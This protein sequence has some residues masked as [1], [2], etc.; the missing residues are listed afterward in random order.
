MWPST[1]RRGG[2]LRTWSFLTEGTIWTTHLRCWHIG[3]A[4]ASGISGAPA[5]L[6]RR[7]RAVA[8]LWALRTS[9][10]STARGRKPGSVEYLTVSEQGRMHWLLLRY[11]NQTPGRSRWPR[12]PGIRHARVAR[13]TGLGQDAGASA[14]GGS[15][16]HATGFEADRTVCAAWRPTTWG[17]VR[18]LRRP[19]DRVALE[20]RSAGVSARGRGS[21]SAG[22]PLDP[23]AD[24]P[25]TLQ[26]PLRKPYRRSAFSPKAAHPAGGVNGSDEGSSFRGR[27]WSAV[28]ASGAVLMLVYMGRER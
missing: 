10:S 27:Q 19:L 22:E 4:G 24:R 21:H 12:A 18:L 20:V 6:C 5:L 2:R 11:A 17:F 15:G 8:G 16:G 13:K 25:R 1:R 14:A 23:S 9:C 28:D 7:T 3:D 26:V